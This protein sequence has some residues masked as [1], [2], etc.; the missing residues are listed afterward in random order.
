MSISFFTVKASQYFITDYLL[1]KYRSSI[2]KSNRQVGNYHSETVHP[3][4]LGRKIIQKL[5]NLKYQDIQMPGPVGSRFEAEP[6][7]ASFWIREENS[8]ACSGFIKVRI[9]ER[10]QKTKWNKYAVCRLRISLPSHGKNLLQ[11]DNFQRTTTT[12]KIPL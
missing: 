11:K 1:T 4:F 9:W 10:K 6:W 12:S 8:S 5:Y 3:E 7:L 2:W